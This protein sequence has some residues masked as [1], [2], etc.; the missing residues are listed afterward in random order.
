MLGRLILLIAA[1]AVYEVNE[2]ASILPPLER[3]VDMATAALLVWALVPHY[4]N[5]TRLGDAILLIV[6]LITGIIFLFF[7]KDWL[8]TL[9][10]SSLPV[11][12]LSTVQAA[13]WDILQLVLL[14]IGIVLIAINREDDWQLRIAT[15]ATLFASHIVSL[16]SQFSFPTTETEVAY[17]VR[18]GNLITFPLLAIVTYRYNLNH[19]L[20]GSG[21]GH[22]WVEH[23]SY[24][25]KLARETIDNREIVS[26]V[27]KSLDMI[28]ELITTEFAAV[29]IRDSEES[30]SIQ[31]M[32]TST[33]KLY[34]SESIER[35]NWILELDDWPAFVTAIENNEQVE[36][37]SN[38]SGARQALKLKQQFGL[39]SLGPLLITPLTVNE[40]NIGLLLLAGSEHWERWPNSDKA[41]SQSVG[42]FLAV[43]FLN[44]SV[45]QIAEVLGPERKTDS[46]S[47][48]ESRIISLQQEYDRAVNQVSSLQGRVTALESQLVTETSRAEHLTNRLA[49]SHFS[50]MVEQIN[51]QEDEIAALKESLVQ[52][53]EAVAQA[54]ASDAGLSA[55]WVM[56][57]VTH[58]SGE[59]E[60]AQTRI[61]ALEARLNSS[62]DGPE[63]N[64]IISR[65][66]QLRTPLTSLGVYTNLLMSESLGELGSRQ[67]S[68]VGRMRS[69]IDRMTGMINQISVS[70]SEIQAEETPEQFVDIRK[71]IESAISAVGLQIKQKRLTLDLDIEEKLPTLPSN[72]GSLYEIVTH[73][74]DGTCRISQK[75]GKLSILAHR[76]SVSSANTVA[77]PASFLHIAVSGDNTALGSSIQAYLVSGGEL[78]SELLGDSNIKPAIDSLSVA[79]H[80]ATAYGGRTWVEYDEGVGSTVS[81]LLPESLNGG[82]RPVQSDVK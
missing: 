58:Y 71:T 8:D 15:I 30:P 7:A 52:A 18:L 72:N 25:L 29:G 46:G 12:Y 28:T 32:G 67:M 35:K 5:A 70:A 78:K 26:A 75:D 10:A 24:L 48:L 11:S 38:G 66:R 55:E 21:F 64:R 65:I 3:A 59:L 17:W 23:L 62:S 9:E 81:V 14:S 51:E 69:N 61:N 41:L 60:D 2:A 40:D 31:F 74:L 33:S 4:S 79:L 13:I 36:L 63:Y 53:E 77:R 82:H 45:N 20:P 56:R 42:D 57:T 50:A 76:E 34:E 6:L 19:M 39:E 68:L 16:F 27:E 1:L 44:S 37:L 43:A 80:L 49:A 22:T 73:L 47:L 54:A